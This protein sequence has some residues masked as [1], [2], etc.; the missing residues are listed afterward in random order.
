MKPPSAVMESAV[1]SAPKVVTLEQ[2]TA[3]ESSASSPSSA[4]QSPAPVDS[5]VPAANEVL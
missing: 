4:L 1:A 5:G 3:C 2:L